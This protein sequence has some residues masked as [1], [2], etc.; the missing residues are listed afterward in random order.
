MEKSQTLEPQ[1]MK[2]LVS[3]EEKTIPARYFVPAADI[4]ET[5]EVLTVVL[6][7]PGVE[8]KNLDI[9]LEDDVL[10]VNAQI[11]LAKYEGNEPVYT[12]YNIGH[13]QRAFALSSKIDQE[14]I[15]ADLNDGVLTLILKK[16]R[17]AMPRRIK[18]S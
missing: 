6:E 7:I 10:R 3:K 18:L 9:K 5:E 12:E 11:D 2:E 8:K 14:G 17:E 16:A 4:F 13:F 1:Q 15:T